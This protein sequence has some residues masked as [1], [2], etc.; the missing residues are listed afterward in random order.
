ML[1]PARY[2][3]KETRTGTGMLR[4]RTELLNAGMP[5]QA[6]SASMPMPCY[7]LQNVFS[8]YSQLVLRGSVFFLT[9]EASVWIGHL[10]NFIVC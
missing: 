9:F 7:G 1:E 5:M 2:L 8:V 10:E 3:K 6:A 4:Y